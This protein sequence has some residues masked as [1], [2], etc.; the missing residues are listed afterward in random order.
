VGVIRNKIW[1][2][3]WANK[4]RTLQVVLIIA[5][6]TAAIGM[7]IGISSL[8][9]PTMAVRWQATNPAMI[10]LAV[11]PAMDENDLIAL[12]RVDGVEEVKGQSSTS[13][14]WRVNP[15]DEWT[16]G[17]LIARADYEDQKLNQLTLVAG[18]WPKDR[19][20]ALER[21]HETAF[22]IPQ[23]G[24][25]TIRVN[26]REHLIQLGGSIYNQLVTPAKCH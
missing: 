14:E 12:K 21:G 1:T 9:T 15:E 8:V 20:F 4:G 6:G 19:V 18:N 17:G 16:S 3:L 25:V 13:I 2:D 5:M 26:D 23:G 22:D 10:N 11:D 7:I 24:Q